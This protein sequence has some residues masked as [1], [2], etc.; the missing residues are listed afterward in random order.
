LRVPL[1]PGCC[2]LAVD[3]TGRHDQ[4]HVGM[5]VQAAA[6]G[7]QHRMG[8]GDPLELGIPAGKGV[9]RLPGGFE[10]QVVAAALLAPEQRPQLG[11]HREGDQEV[12]HRQQLGQLPLDPALAVRVLAVGAAAVAAGVGNLEAVV[13][14]A[15]AEHHQVAALAAAAAHRLQGLAMAGQQLGAMQPLQFALVAVDHLGE[16]HHH[17]PSCQRSWKPSS[18][19]SMRSLL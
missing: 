10:Q 1:L 13:A 12:L 14:V 16:E 19:I 2:W 3:G 6:V 18:S 7:V 5:E 17:T 4:V 8:T 9:H 15:A 11:R